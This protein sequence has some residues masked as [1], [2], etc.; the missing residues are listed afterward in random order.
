MPSFEQDHQHLLELSNIFEPTSQ[1]ALEYTFSSID[2]EV[3][4]YELWT[5]DIDGPTPSEAIDCTPHNWYT[6]F[7]FNCAIKKLC[8]NLDGNEFRELCDYAFGDYDE[9]LYTGHPLDLY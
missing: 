3:T 2:N 8:A 6:Q 5:E 1:Y 7:W 9:T 4:N